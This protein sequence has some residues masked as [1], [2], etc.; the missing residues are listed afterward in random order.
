[1]NW[2][3]VGAV[4]EGLGALAVFV[5]LVYLAMQV[6]QTRREVQRAANR[7]RT[8]AARQ[9]NLT[10]ALDERW[11]KVYLKASVG[12]SEAQASAERAPDAFLAD[13]MTKGGITFEEA[14]A[15]D[16]GLL[17]TWLLQTQIV[18]D[19][20]E[21]SEGQRVEVLRFLRAAY[22]GTYPVSRLWYDNRKQNLNPDL[23]RLIDRLLAQPV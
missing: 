18:E 20:D 2:E 22:D 6:S 7:A 3:A 8:D 10:F 16:R 17:A 15:V 23:V 19:I 9:H 4:S 5:T 13:L 14:M 21:L 1:M 12:L 11:T